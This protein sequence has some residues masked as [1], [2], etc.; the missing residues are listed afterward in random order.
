MTDQ[1][2]PSQVHKAEKQ[3][4]YSKEEHDIEIKSIQAQAEHIKDEVGQLKSATSHSIADS[5]DR[6]YRLQVGNSA[7]GRTPRTSQKSY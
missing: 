1:R 3:L 6:I 2:P 5:S 7:A 4:T